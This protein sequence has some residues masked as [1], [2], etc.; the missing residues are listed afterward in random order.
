MFQKKKVWIFLLLL[1]LY[2]AGTTNVIL[3]LNVWNTLGARCPP[4]LGDLPASPGL[5]MAVLSLA[6]SSWERSAHP[7]F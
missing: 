7:M 6:R 1:G 4:P 3:C 2:S 5:L